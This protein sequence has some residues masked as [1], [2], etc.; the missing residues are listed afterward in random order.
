AAKKH[1]GIA[2]I[3]IE[4]ENLDLNQGFAWVADRCN[5]YI[6]VLF[7]LLGWHKVDNAFDIRRTDHDIGAELQVFDGYLKN[8]PLFQFTDNPAACDTAHHAP[9]RVVSRVKSSSA[10]TGA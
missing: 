3:H 7:E 2:Q 10:T 6:A 5:V 9:P 4:G 8:K 1:G